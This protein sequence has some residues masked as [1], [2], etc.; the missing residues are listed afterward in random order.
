MKYYIWAKKYSSGREHMIWWR[1]KANGYTDDI[2]EA[3][4]YSECDAMSRVRGTDDHFAVPE[5]M[6]DKVPRRHC[7]VNSWKLVNEM[8]QNSLQIKVGDQHG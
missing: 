1:P 8:Q 3:G 7:I 6:I 5:E 2:T 4:L